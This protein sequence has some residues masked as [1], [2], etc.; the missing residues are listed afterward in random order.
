M[1]EINSFFC[2]D[3]LKIWLV[4]YL[5]VKWWRKR[6]SRQLSRLFVHSLNGHKD[7]G[8]A[9]LRSGASNSVPVSYMNS[10]DPRA[11]AIFHCFV[12]CTNRKLE[13]LGHIVDLCCATRPAPVLALLNTYYLMLGLGNRTCFLSKLQRKSRKSKHF[14]PNSRAVI[15]CKW[16]TVNLTEARSWLRWSHTHWAVSSWKEER[17][18][19]HR[20]GN[21]TL[22]SKDTTKVKKDRLRTTYKQTHVHTYGGGLMTQKAETVDM[23]PPAQGC[24]QP[25]KAGR[26]TRQ[27]LA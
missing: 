8:Y 6:R 2:I 7:H 4:N 15:T 14:V 12:R 10:R 18:H 19:T 13:Q 3:F 16:E 20:E 26:G 24:W 11:W 9:K 25:P 22:P 5:K 1:L 27:G 21:F 23:P 17:G